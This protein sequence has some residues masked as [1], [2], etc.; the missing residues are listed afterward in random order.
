MRCK[1]PVLE[2]KIFPVSQVPPRAHE[3]MTGQ[4]HAEILKGYEEC[5]IPADKVDQAPSPPVAPVSQYDLIIPGEISLHIIN[6]LVASGF[7]VCVSKQHPV[8]FCCLDTHCQRQFFPFPDMVTSPDKRG[9]QM[10]ILPLQVNQEDFRPVF[11]SIINNNYL[12]FRVVLLQ[13][14]G[15]V[16]PEICLLVPGTD[17]DRNREPSDVGMNRSVKQNFWKNK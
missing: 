1:S 14:Q 6:P 3:R 13:Y 11:R 9:T 5:F 15:Q 10:G 17:D 8:M 2:E 16:C 4:G 12:I 7:A